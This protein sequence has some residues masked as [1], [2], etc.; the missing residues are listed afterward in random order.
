[1]RTSPR[2]SQN[3]EETRLRSVENAS[4][5]GA[6][7]SDVTGLKE[8]FTSLRGEM[9]SG[10][11]A[12]FNKIDRMAAPKA[13]PWAAVISAIA[14]A[15]TVAGGLVAIGNSW[16]SQAIG[17]VNATTAAAHSRIDLSAQSIGINS[18]RITRIEIQTAADQATV[19]ERLR[20]IERL[21]CNFSLNPSP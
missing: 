12:I 2:S 3:T 15:V 5:L 8:D 14:V 6:L 7:E 13:T 20:W 11:D 18:D 16:V 19:R 10:F 21:T 4:K 17:A 1:M 9:R